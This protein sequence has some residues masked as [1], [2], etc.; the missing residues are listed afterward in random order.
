MS[1][2]MISSKTAGGRIYA[3]AENEGHMKNAGTRRNSGKGRS[4]IYQCGNRRSWLDIK[5]YNLGE[6]IIHMWLS[7]RQ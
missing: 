3:T 7:T 6:D 5:Q 2:K 4:Y 1:E